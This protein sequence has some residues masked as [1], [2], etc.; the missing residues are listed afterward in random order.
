MQEKKK[1]D[2]RQKKLK[3]ILKEFNS[4]D[5]KKISKAI[6]S[7]EIHGDSS[8]IEPLAERLLDK[9]LPEKNRKE[10][11]ELL[12]SLKDTSTR[13]ELIKLI[14]NDKFSSI[15]HEILSVIWNTKIDFS[16]YI[17]DFVSIAIHGTFQEAIEAMTII[18]HLEGPFI[19][20]DLLEAQL[21]LKDYKEKGQQDEQ[22]TFILSEI[23]L[24][25]R[26]FIYQNDTDDGLYLEE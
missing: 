18:E 12:C 13:E 3:E 6:K 16:D 10:I 23:A 17:A 20:E 19:E 15:R 5:T 2:A 7:L 24:K 9:K 26:E 22:K 21:H 8:V 4:Q 1:K 11:I 14:E 25:L